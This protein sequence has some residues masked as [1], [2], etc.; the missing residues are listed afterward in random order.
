M[1][2]N[3]CKCS[4]DSIQSMSTVLSQSP[5][6]LD[7]ILQ[8]G[9]EFTSHLMTIVDC[10][11]CITADKMLNA[12]SQVALR[13][14]SFYESAYLSTLSPRSNSP[15]QGSTPD[16]GST[17]TSRSASDP[18]RILSLS[19][20]QPPSCQNFTSVSSS[21]RTPTC[22]FTSSDMKFGHLSIDGSEAQMLAGVVLVDSC[23]DLNKALQGLKFIVDE[24]LESTSDPSFVQYKALIWRCLNRLARLT[25]QLQLD[26]SSRA[27]S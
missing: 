13:L 11:V 6:S 2:Q 26:T 20:P 18:S 16:Q 24:V 3:Q 7:I 12:V 4:F 9:R 14:V 27:S 8:T 5:L 25:G 22:L 21:P 15:E 23:L 10:D 17:Q 19:L 1:E